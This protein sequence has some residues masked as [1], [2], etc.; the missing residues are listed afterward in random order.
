MDGLGETLRILLKA[1]SLTQVHSFEISRKV[2]LV[3][4]LYYHICIN[5][6][7]PFYF[8]FFKEK[9]REWYKDEYKP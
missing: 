8:V 6:S 4:S 3:F 7:F 9:N 5:L 1:V 2:C